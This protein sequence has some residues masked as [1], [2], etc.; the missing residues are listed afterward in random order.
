MFA[1]HN[2]ISVLKN[3][4]SFAEGAQLWT[5]VLK[6]HCR[7][8]ATAREGHVERL[9]WKWVGSEEGV[10]A[11]NWETKEHFMGRVMTFIMK[12]G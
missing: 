9:G 12:N 1:I 6:L 3:A 7:K 4:G 8:L 11:S 10:T 2:V 5:S